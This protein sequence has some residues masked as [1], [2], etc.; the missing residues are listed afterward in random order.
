M[1]ENEEEITLRTSD[2]EPLEIAI[3][4]ITKRENS[5]SAMPAAGK[6]ISKR[7][8]RDLMEFLGS[9]KVVEPL[10]LN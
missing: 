5:I 6:L 7:E 8:L 9:L 1:G 10:T 4:R 3:S 2:A